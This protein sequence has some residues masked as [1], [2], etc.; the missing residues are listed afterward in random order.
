MNRLTIIV[1]SLFLTLVFPTLTN[2]AAVGNCQPIYGGGESCL[3]QTNLTV[4]KKVLYP[5]SNNFVDNLKSTDSK[6]KSGEIIN[7]ELTITNKSRETLKKVEVIDKLPTYIT[8]TSGPGN[9][10][11]KTKTL[12]FEFYDLRKNESRKFMVVG[13]ISDIAKPVCSL[14][15]VSV[16]SGSFRAEDNTRFCLETPIKDDTGQTTTP[17]TKGGQPVMQA[18]KGI[19]Q[20]PATGPE[21]LGVFGLIPVLL[22]GIL[23]RKKTVR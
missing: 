11:K 17:V 10:D 4:D 5:Q 14:N 22:S 12:K 6:Y 8:Y 13:T 3:P 20:S 19:T 15:Y 2:A 23:I 9:F 21:L 7:F 1:L 18:P 16:R